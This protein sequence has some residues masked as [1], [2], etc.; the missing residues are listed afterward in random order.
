MAVAPHGLRS[1]KHESGA[2]WSGRGMVAVES[3]VANPAEAGAPP[4]AGAFGDLADSIDADLGVDG[5]GTLHVSLGT[6]SAVPFTQIA[7]TSTVTSPYASTTFVT[8]LVRGAGS[9]GM[10]DQNAGACVLSSTLLGPGRATTRLNLGASG[11]MPCWRQLWSARSTDP[12]QPHLALA[13]IPAP[14][15]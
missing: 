13:G 9:G 3:Q 1:P 8:W 7:F 6:G 12:M 11:W 10:S 15:G 5:S 4:S 14:A 2:A